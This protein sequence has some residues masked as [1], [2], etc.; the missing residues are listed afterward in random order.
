MQIHWAAMRG[1]LQ[2]VTCYLDSGVTIDARNE[3][4]ET[5]LI[6][7]AGD[8]RAD[9][10]IVQFLIDA[11]AD[12]NAVSRQLEHTPLMRAAAAGDLAKVACLLNAGANPRFV[13]RS[14]YTAITNLPFHRGPNHLDVLEKLLAAGVDP[15]VITEYGECPLRIAISWGN[16]RAV[17]QL[18]H[19]GVDRE[20]A[21][22]SD[23]MWVIAVGSVEDVGREI[24]RGA[25][26]AAR[27]YWSM[28]PWLLS[29]LTGDVDKARL[30]LKAGA[31]FDDRGRCGKTNLM[32]SVTCN[33]V[34]MT[35]W[36]L[37]NHADPAATDDFGNTPLITAAGMGA[38]KCVRLLLHA[39]APAD[40]QT[41]STGSVGMT[42]AANP[43]VVRELVAAGADINTV[44]GDGY[45]LL[46]SAAE[47]GNVEF[48][49]ALL[50]MGADVE[51]TST[52][53]TALHTAVL[54]DQLE[55]VRLLLDA[56]ANPN[57]Q[58]VDQ[59]TP[60][61]LARTS[62]CVDLLLAAGAR[63]DFAD[64]TGAEVVH[65]HSDPEILSRLQEAGAGLNPHEPSMPTVLHRAAETGDLPLARYLLQGGADVNGATVWGLTP[66][67]SAAERGHVGVMEL[68]LS[69]G[70]D[71][72][73]TDETGRT[74][75]FYAAA[76]E[77]FT[78]FQLKQDFAA[79]DHAD[80]LEG[81]DP[82][83]AA[84]MRETLDALKDKNI[85]PQWNDFGYQPNDD[86]AAITLLIQSGAD[87]DARDGE[88]LTPLLLAAR[89]GR[90]TRVAA[91]VR[92][93]ADARARDHD[94]KSAADQAA[95]HHDP[96]QAAEI[97]RI[98]TRR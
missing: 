93:N 32:H 41:A 76:P 44:G 5:A 65:H 11:G 7:A 96:A 24:G 61:M 57:A 25:D 86:V 38:A 67:M 77:G 6:C 40:Y 53:D 55:I 78:A 36:L 60:L 2:A 88:G 31:N 26:L 42:A 48:T 47:T 10:A 17:R 12:V 13:N 89:C 45:H 51:T 56:G 91:L 70:A 34:E 50:E 84:S 59:C 43:Q 73:A 1:D 29:L 49:R 9:V 46:K 92:H 95:Q 85:A 79:Q 90:P 58:D 62:E 18:L 68:L 19:H 15:N 81:L 20:P 3:N 98:L 94:R 21:G 39:G 4:G 69:A 82:E 37:A 33:H 30:V 54:W 71:I 27:D 80:L 97:L 75:L 14:G 16:F 8:R 23:L 87:I 83:L 28:T 22:F 35:K 72:D 66:L 52:G 74:A 63:V 64:Q